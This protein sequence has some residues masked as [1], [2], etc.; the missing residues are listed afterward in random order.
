MARSLKER[1]DDKRVQLLKERVSV[2]DKQLLEEHRVANLL[3]EA[4]DE[5][6]LNKVSGIVDKLTKLK[7]MGI[8][9]LDAGIDQALAE[10]NKYTA[11]GPITAAWTK[12]KKLVGI[13][14]PVVK[15]TTFASA[16]E[17]GFGQV[18][19]ILKNNGINL[20]AL[21][22]PAQLEKTLSQAIA[23]QQR[24]TT[25]KADDS[26]LGSKKGSGL[27][28]AP[29]P[30]INPSQNEAEAP[31]KN[32]AAGKGN[33]ESK[34][35]TIIAQLT[36]A[37][38]PGGIFGAFK[39]VP[40]VDG[41]QLANDLMNAKLSSFSRIAKT[42]NSGDKSAEVAAALK[43]EITGHGEAETKGTEKGE[44]T[45]AA[46][47]TS[48]SEP[49]KPTTATTNT[50]ATGTATPKPQGGGAEQNYAV[51]RRK[52]VPLLSQLKGPG[53][54]KNLDGI[55]KKLVDAGLDPNKL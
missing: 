47:Q 17:K 50:T 7:G 38:S 48:P 24:S 8:R 18:S 40:Y 54:A 14:N 53:G 41:G 1:Y 16:L 10:L 43:P 51:A 21:K 29:P 36:K 5:E 28:S 35:K 11:G 31:V 27:G 39:K 44:P 19:R 49:G 20:D 13:D 25:G 37:F 46:A 12:M 23:D 3:V 4:M 15:I 22:G 26:V 30:T 45:K 52:I 55:V 32:D 9:S 33:T 34:V 42:V 2:I 6:D